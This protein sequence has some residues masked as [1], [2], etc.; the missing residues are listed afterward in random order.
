MDDHVARLL[1]ALPLVLLVGVGAL[2]ALKRLGVGGGTP[3]KPGS[4]A[5]VLRGTTVLTEHTKAMLV[6]V[7]GRTF[8]VVES[9]VSLQVQ[10][11]DAPATTLPPQRLTRWGAKSN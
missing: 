9:T 2:L 4:D 6:E 11:L 7:G 8:M 5:P 10:A 1:W 3:A